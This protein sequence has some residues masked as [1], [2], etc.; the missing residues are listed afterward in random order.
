MAEDLSIALLDLLR[1]TDLN[2]LRVI[3]IPRGL[4][5]YTVGHLTRLAK[6][7]R[8]LAAVP[9]LWA[10]GAAFRGVGLPDCIRQAEETADQVAAFA[11]G[12]P[13]AVSPVSS[14]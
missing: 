9:G 2:D 12:R 13:A 4:P 10:T 1:K 11:L 8:A 3:R 7:E 14:D 5:Q 6:A